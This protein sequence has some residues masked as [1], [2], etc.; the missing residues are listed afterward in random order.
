MSLFFMKRGRDW[1]DHWKW[2]KRK[3]TNYNWQSRVRDAPASLVQRIWFIKKLLRRMG[4]NY[5]FIQWYIMNFLTGR[6]RAHPIKNRKQH[7]SKGVKHVPKSRQSL[8]QSYWDKMSK[9]KIKQRKLKAGPVW[10]FP[11]GGFGVGSGVFKP[12]LA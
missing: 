12:H 7:K 10:G 2:R 9:Q 1:D 5:M 6:S 11:F 4:Y 3:R 8:S